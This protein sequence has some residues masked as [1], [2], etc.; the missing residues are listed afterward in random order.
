[1]SAEVHS[2]TAALAATVSVGWELIGLIGILGLTLAAT[3]AG[4]ISLDAI[5]PWGRSEKSAAVSQPA[6]TTV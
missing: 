1:M 6:L 4:R 2:A 5:L 3:G